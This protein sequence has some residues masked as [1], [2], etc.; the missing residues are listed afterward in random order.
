MSDETVKDDR[1]T[2]EPISELKEAETPVKTED[3][4]AIELFPGASNWLNAGSSWLTT[5]REKTMKTFDMVKKDL[6]EFSEAMSTEVA[7][8]TSAAKGGL[9]STVT[10]VKQQ[11]QYL[12]RLVTPEDEEKDFA[13]EVQ[14]EN[15][16]ND[17]KEDIISKVEKSAS[18]GFGWMKSL[19]DTVTDTVKNLGVEESMK[20]E[21]AFTEQIKPRVMR[22]TKI[23]QIKLQEIQTNEGTYLEEPSNKEAFESWLTR[24]N[25]SEYDGEINSLLSN[26]P[27]MRQ[28][29]S[30]LVPAVIKADIFWTRYFFAV[31]MAEVDN[32][33]NSTFTLKELNVKT[34][35]KGKNVIEKND[36]PGSDGSMAIVEEPTSPDKSD[37]WSMCS[38]KNDELAN[39]SEETDA[40]P[41]T[42]KPTNPDSGKKED[43]WVD[44]DE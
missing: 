29:Y 38:E 2:A 32:E 26:Y 13:E 20:G 3:D 10:V 40:G 4:P 14:E 17:P 6:S 41:V 23:S 34:D 18:M 24:F 39:N 22:N 36:S 28:I 27:P 12:E 37:D 1:V 44:W 9:D 15:V 19:V 11:A 25:K 42:P 33:M 8:L 7:G 16:E 30:S 5:A 35:S 31:E 21:E 43:G